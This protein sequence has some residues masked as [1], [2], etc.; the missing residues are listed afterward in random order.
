MVEKTGNIAIYI[1]FSAS[2]YV[3][4]SH[5]NSTT[6]HRK[7]AAIERDERLARNLRANLRRRKAAVRKG[8]TDG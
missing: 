7:Q 4:M 1:A 5:L 6:S 3:F 2:K 8:K